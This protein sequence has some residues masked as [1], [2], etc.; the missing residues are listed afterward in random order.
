MVKPQHCLP[1]EKP[2]GATFV[3]AHHPF[4]R[5]ACVR[6]QL[7]PELFDGTFESDV[8]IETEDP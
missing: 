1:G 5:S 2:S 8:G 3:V 7:V 6:L 4:P